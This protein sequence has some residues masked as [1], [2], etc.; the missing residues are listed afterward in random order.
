MIEVRPV[1]PGEAEGNAVTA[2]RIK[3]VTAFVAA[4]RGRRTIQ[5]ILIANN[6]IAAVK[7]L[8]SIRKWAYATFGDEHTIEFVAMATPEDIAANAEYV[9]MADEYVAVPGGPNNQNYANVQLIV[10]IAQ[11]SRVHAVWAGWGHASENPRLPESLAAL[12]IIFIGPPAAAMRALGDKISS[13]I[14]AESADVPILPWS[15]SGLKVSPDEN[16]RIESFPPE[17][18]SQAC[19]YNAKEGLLAAER[20]GFP[21]MIK[22]SEGG[23]GKGIRS[24]TCAEDFAVNFDFVQR[25]VPGSPIFLMQL[26]QEARHLEVQLLADEYGEAISLYG[27]DCSVQRRHQKIIEEAPVT[28]VKEYEKWREME[29][30]AVRLA[31]LVGYVS[32][33][34]VEYLYDVAQER[35]SFLELNPRLQVEHP[36][37]EMVS[38]VNLPAAQ[39]QIAMGIP[40]NCIEDIRKMYGRTSIEEAA[41]TAEGSSQDGR[42][43]PEA[44]EDTIDFAN[45]EQRQPYGHVMAC[46]ITA[47]N[48]DAGFKPGGGRIMEL[49]F[50]GSTD[51]WGYF[52]VASAGN[53]HEFA[54]SQFG[55]IFSWGA[56]RN[57]ARRNLVLAL[58]EM[59]IRGD[60]RTTLE[61][62]VNLLEMD[63]FVKGLQ[64]TAWL[65]ALIRTKFN[66]Q[67]MDP[68]TV[69]IAGASWHAKKAFDD[70]A[71]RAIELCSKGQCPPADVLDRTLFV[72]FNYSQVQYKID[73]L[74]TGPDQLC[75]SLNNSQMTVRL[76]RLSDGGILLSMREGRTFVLYGKEEHNGL[77]ITINGRTVIVE[78]ENDPSLVRSPSPGKLVRYLIADGT[79]VPAGAAIAEVEIMKMYMPLTVSETGTVTIVKA[80]GSSL[81]A[82]DIV[83]RLKLADASAI[84]RV[85]I[86]AATFDEE[87]SCAVVVGGKLH[88]QLEEHR[89]ILTNIIVAG[90]YDA[91]QQAAASTLALTLSSNRE[92]RTGGEFGGRTCDTKA[93]VRAF[94]AECLNVQMP[95]LVFEELLS[96]IAG[97]ISPV[98][99][100]RLSEIVRMGLSLRCEE[101]TPLLVEGAAL[102]EAYAR[103]CDSRDAPLVAA[104]LAGIQPHLR[105]PVAFADASVAAL[106]DGFYESEAIFDGGAITN[107]VILHRLKAKFGERFEDYFAFFAA[108]A[109]SASRAVALSTLTIEAV[110]SLA[111]QLKSDSATLSAI[112]RLTRLTG[113]EHIKVA[114]VAREAL[115]NAQLP[116]LVDLKRKM[117]GK[118]E[119]Y[120]P[121]EHDAFVSDLVIGCSYHMDVLPLFFLHPTESVRRIAA[122]IYI[123]RV[124]E[125]FDFIETSSRSI[126]LA[127]TSGDGH[128]TVDLFSWIVAAPPAAIQSDQAMM[129]FPPTT[130][131]TFGGETSTPT[132]E[133]YERRAGTFVAFPSMEVACNSFAH[134]VQS[135]RPIV[136]QSAH[137]NILYIAVPDGGLS[138]D[139][140]VAHWERLLEATNEALGQSQIRRITLVLVRPNSTS[141]GY[142]T[143]REATRWHEDCQV[144]HMEPAMSYLLELPRILKN[145]KINLCHADPTGQIHIY[146]GT[147]GGDCKAGRLFIR[148]LVRPMQTMRGH[149]TLASLAQ[150]G[151]RIFT[152]VL[153]AVAMVQS[154]Q[155]KPLDCNHLY[156]YVLPT[157]YADPNAA[158]DMFRSLMA[159]TEDKLLKLRVMEGEI[160]MNMARTRGDPTERFRFFLWNETGFVNRVVAYREVKDARGGLHPVLKSLD[161]LGELE[162]CIANDVHPPLS[163]LQIKRNRTHALETSYVYDFP[164]IFRRAVELTWS[165]AKMVTLPDFFSSTELVLL[166]TPPKGGAA[167]P[168]M[169][170]EGGGRSAEEDDAALVEVD[171]PAGE[172]TIGMVAWHMVIR[173][174]HNTSPQ[175]IIVI[176]N[177]IDFE[178]G[179]FGVEEDR[180]FAAAS[181]L[182]RRNKWPRIFLSA[183]SGAR[184][185]LAD[186][187]RTLLT[188]KWIDPKVPT[189]G[190]E[191]L[192]LCEADYESVRDSVRVEY[193]PAEK[194]YRITDILTGL[195][196][197]N[198]SGSALIA[199]E[200]SRAYT[201]AFTLTLVT[202]R[203][204]G[205]GA[206]LVRLGQRVI[207]KHSQPIILTGVQALNQ[208]LGRQVYGS[209]LQIGGPQI[210]AANGVSHLVVR[211]DLEGVQMAIKWIDFLPRFNCKVPL[212]ESCASLATPSLGD[213]VRA[214]DDVE[215]DVSYHPPRE[216]AYDPRLLVNGCKSG[217]GKSGHLDGLLDRNS[218]V[219]YQSMWA[220]GVVVGRGRLGG[221]PVA[222]LLVETR[223]TETLIPAD[224]ASP[225]SASLTIAQAGQ[226]W[227]PDS[228]YKTAQFIRDCNHGEGLPLIILANWRGFS[229]GQRDLFDEIL[230]FGSYIVDALRE[231][232]PP[233]F[234]YLPP[235]A[236]LRGGSWVV[237]DSA[238]NRECIEMYADPSARGGIMEAEGL[239]AIK[240][241]GQHLK[242]LMHRLLPETHTSGKAAPPPGADGSAADGEGPLM[243]SMRHIAC[244]FADLHDRPGRMLAMGT[245]RGVIPWVDS[246]RFFYHR[247]RVRLWLDRLVGRAGHLCGIAEAAGEARTTLFEGVKRALHTEWLPLLGI[248]IA[249]ARDRD[250]AD[251]M[252]RNC[253]SLEQSVAKWSL[254]R[255]AQDMGALLGHVDSRSDRK[256]LLCHLLD[257]IASEEAA[258]PLAT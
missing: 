36:C 168:R 26:A 254:T 63:T 187:L 156:M 190:Y 45:E 81:E 241:R 235:H 139:A 53:V 31:K 146:K 37:T 214:T 127:S 193:V 256:A 6:G 160:R 86:S 107:D 23:G 249:T 247:L 77:R 27:R 236:Q 43:T 130:G 55:H 106:L 204:V 39:L 93:L 195:G 121:A 78:D 46:R 165:A 41:P 32:A 133:P 28:A 227:Y 124:Y 184:I 246:R 97:R 224:P 56:T 22:A 157:F 14:V 34:T 65:D 222:V 60:F 148:V 71:L 145:Y 5:R 178:I 115:M 73:V 141:M 174:A 242:N 68:L 118:L 80:A 92:E 171:R 189:K 221:L 211:T 179:S 212:M 9:R 175:D 120:S 188:P 199:G 219:E 238:I 216:E 69:A 186:E 10:D 196:V 15:G 180:L 140:T 257:Q 248:D 258:S 209:N 11:R 74:Q 161:G 153:D 203:S 126:T 100:G 12:G 105:G 200:T 131:Y 58:K 90:Y 185:G 66:G 57:D 99:E 167:T 194:H 164:A 166:A 119:A 3:T 79:V 123:R 42:P 44:A 75:L 103:D 223:T 150:D 91:G 240:F 250:V 149:N 176:S 158:A 233:I 172:N 83:A 113:P 61:Y 152:E 205:I 59:S 183:N 147:N 62:L 138:D 122:E 151:R 84:Q 135:I 154:R 244:T 104:L 191:Y 210:M 245:I 88:Q 20:I 72:Q 197:E 94:V 116:S 17:I 114:Q 16:G 253:G 228:A 215:R 38:R 181:R 111:S 25:E 170:G 217:D 76:L 70:R 98:L 177:D 30:A 207:Q 89:R 226:V 51:V 109:N 155:P 52:S 50:R 137:K 24:V 112:R 8:R 142:Y 19:I 252:D 239:V 169:G 218:F 33:G 40:L 125:A 243:E 144:R 35:F 4:S 7:E 232:R 67:G 1:P 117:E 159:M 206:Y 237:V 225:S 18:Y 143:F 87:D 110:D 96:N 48:P 230:K 128:A 255:I 251:V 229:G 95:F 182:A 101:M 192:Y 64:T 136:S 208:L 202:G 201:E 213:R 2:A 21:L 173:T 108:H 198:L 163:R 129:H 82:G 134:L 220:R 132:S 47:E 13:M 162:G 231:Y 54:D 102:I 49:T 234:V 85:R 29:R